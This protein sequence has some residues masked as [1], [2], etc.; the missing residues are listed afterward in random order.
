MADWNT[1]IYFTVT[2]LFYGNYEQ[3]SNVATLNRRASNIKHWW[4]HR[5]NTDL[6]FASLIM[7]QLKRK[8]RLLLGYSCKRCTLTAATHQ[9]R[10]PGLKG[11]FHRGLEL[12]YFRNN[13]CE[14]R[15]MGLL[16]QK[17]KNM[18]HFKSSTPIHYKSCHA[19]QYWQGLF[20]HT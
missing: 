9:N 3:A 19:L 12:L 2:T 5:L 4:L 6:R 16:S 18:S 17:P 15:Q 20:H 8:Q 11:S 10:D 13:S 1:S 14:S 7:I